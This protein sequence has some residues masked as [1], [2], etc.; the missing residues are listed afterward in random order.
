M[1][2]S[3]GQIGTLSRFFRDDDQ[4]LLSV[5]AKLKNHLEQNF[6]LHHNGK[7]FVFNQTSKQRFREQIEQLYPDLNIR[8]GLPKGLDRIGVMAHVQDDKLADVNP[9]DNFVLATAYHGKLRVFGRDV[10]LPQ[11]TSLRLPLT[12][13]DKASYKSLIVVENLDIFDNWYVAKIPPELHEALVLYRG[14]DSVAKGLKALLESIEDSIEV[15]MCP[16]LDPKGL[17]SC[18]TT[19]NINGILA[20]NLEDIQTQLSQYSQM[21]KFIDQ[22]NSVSY[23]MKQQWRAWQSLISHVIENNL[24]I[25]QQAILARKLPLVVYKR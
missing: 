7:G 23:L 10:D 9:N 22:Q 6:D 3:K 15:M 17:E 24:A 14:H 18:F 20:P 25:M 5:S 1:A 12:G 8:Q 13:I 11:G 2:L 4:M 16:D 19:P 21:Q